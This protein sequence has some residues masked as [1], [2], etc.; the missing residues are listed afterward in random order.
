MKMAMLLTTFIVMKL[1]Y[2]KWLL[3]NNNNISKTAIF[4]FVT[5]TAIH[6]YMDLAMK[7]GH[8]E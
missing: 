1:S 7:N 4:H 6:F 2:Q 5:V 3:R 8:F